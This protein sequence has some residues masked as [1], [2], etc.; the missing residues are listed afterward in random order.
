M[1]DMIIYDSIALKIFQHTP[2]NIPQTPNQ[3]FMNEFLSFGGLGKPGVCSRGMLG[4]LELR[5]NDSVP[6]INGRIPFVLPRLVRLG[7]GTFFTKAPE[8]NN[9]LSQHTC[10][11]KQSA[12]HG[13]SKSPVTSRGHPLISG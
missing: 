9:T 13:I 1:I 3:Q 10:V 2:W 11:A 4:F 5:C 7:V 6:K 8:K 12:S